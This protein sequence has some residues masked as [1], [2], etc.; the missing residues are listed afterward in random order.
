MLI[1]PQSRLQWSLQYAEQPWAGPGRAGPG[2][3]CRTKG[4]F[5]WDPHSPFPA[6]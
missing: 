5:C 1:K 6:P 3:A 4:G 2:G